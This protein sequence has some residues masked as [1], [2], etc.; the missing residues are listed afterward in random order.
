MPL[1]NPWFAAEDL[2]VTPD[3]PHALFS[4]SRCG[5]V[6]DGTFLG[7]EKDMSCVICLPERI[8]LEA[9]PD[10]ST[11]RVMFAAVCAVVPKRI[12]IAGERRRLKG[13]RAFIDALEAS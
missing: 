10:S 9:A 13:S 5:S 4:S 6:N 11:R 8:I 2:A 7:I 12:A 3:E 1:P